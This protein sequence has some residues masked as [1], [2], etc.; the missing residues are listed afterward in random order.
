MV[1]GPSTPLSPVMFGFGVHLLS[2]IQV[3]DE[4]ALLES[5]AAGLPFRKMNGTRRV[6]LLRSNS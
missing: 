6:S 5:I 3:I 2:G 4:A 1:L